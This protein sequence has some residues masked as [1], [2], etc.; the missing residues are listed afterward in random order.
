MCVNK[1]IIEN[2]ALTVLGVVAC[3][4]VKRENLK[5]KLALQFP[6]KFELFDVLFICEDELQSYETLKDWWR[7]KFFNFCTEKCSKKGKNNTPFKQLIGLT[8]LIMAKIDNSL[9]TLHSNTKE[10]ITSMVLNL[11]Q[12]TAI[13]DGSLKKVITG[14]F[15]SG[16]SIV[17]QEIIK[18]LCNEAEEP[19][20][21]YYICCD[22]FSLFEVEMN[23][24]VN[25]DI[26]DK[27]KVNII[28]NNLL[29]MWQDM[30][31]KQDKKKDVS[32]PELLQY[33]SENSST[34]VNFVLDE[35]SGE[36]VNE[37]DAD[38]LKKLFSSS[39]KES[40]VVFIPK[41]IEKNR[42]IIE[43]GQKH[44]IRNNCFDEEKLGTKNV[45]L[46]LSMR[47]PN[48]VKSLID[49]A[50]DT[51]SESRTVYYLKDNNLDQIKLKHAREEI[52]N[53]IF[54]DNTNEGTTNMSKPLEN[55]NF[56][57]TQIATQ[58]NYYDDD[59]DVAAKLSNRESVAK[60]NRFL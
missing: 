42:S 19:T 1:A 23:K 58:K 29:Q 40:L 54:Q 45:N 15:G 25:N 38:Q 30:C 7:G 48:R 34:T 44:Q 9:P 12:I 22:H 46:Q 51:F 11:E 33:Y 52:S 35:L 59:L 6:C 18:R 16:K 28:C 39:L 17:G 37:E 10:Q 31:K 55:S 2:E 50:Q 13:N 8:S 26:K 47:V 4:S 27:G 32:L 49:V 24:F 5:E 41:S 57:E 20:T 60:S 43:D 56:I 3:P 21:L 36:C 53:D 14:G